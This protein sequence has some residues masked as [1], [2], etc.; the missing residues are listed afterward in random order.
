[1][2]SAPKRKRRN[3]SRSS[4]KGAD[5]LLR[6]DRAQPRLR[7]GEHGDAREESPGGYSLRGSKTWIS[8][9]PIA[10]LFLIWAKTADGRIRGFLAEKGAKGL[11]A[12]AIH[13]KVGLRTSITGEVVMDEVF[14]PEEN[15]LPGVDGLKGPF[16]CLNAARYGIAW[17]ALGAAE[18]CWHRARQYVLDRKQFRPAARREPAGPEKARRHADRNLPRA[19]GR[20]ALRPHEGRRHD[21]PRSPRS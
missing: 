20:A 16:T 9:A 15:L 14:V 10:D 8:N 12:P 4:A 11:S 17:G 1:M 18:D 2:N 13:G 6:L 5:R 7:P 19:A 21:T 3:T